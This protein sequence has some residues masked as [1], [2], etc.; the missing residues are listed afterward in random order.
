MIN[1]VGALATQLYYTV[2]FSRGRRGA[3]PPGAKVMQVSELR[4]NEP[5]AWASLPYSELLKLKRNDREPLQLQALQLRFDRLRG[6]IPALEILADK[7]GIAHIR[8][9]DD[10]LAVAFDH[11]VYKS[12]PM[13]LIE[14]REFKRFTAWLQRLTTHDLRRGPTRAACDS[15]DG[16]L[17][18]ARRARHDHRSLDRHDRQAE[19]RPPLAQRMAAWKVSTYFESTRAATGVDRRKRHIPTFYPGYRGG[20]QTM[21]K[22]LSAVQRRSR[23]AVWSS[24]HTALRLRTMSSDLL[25]LAARLQSAEDKGELE[26]CGL[27]PRCSSSARTDRG[28]PAPRRDLEAWFTKLAEEY[29]GQRVRIGGT[30]ADLTGRHHGQGEGHQVRVRARLRDVSAAAA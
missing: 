11:R 1:S 6:R 25:S 29:R 12:Y 15:V 26:R 21:L 27:D 13:S 17:E 5:M 3:A 16:W 14:K 22:M 2:Y 18:P 28:R 24:Y 7:Q 23:P 4:A 30:F 19:L 8:N 9:F 20:H 10:A